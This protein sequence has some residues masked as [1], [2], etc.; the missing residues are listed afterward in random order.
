[1]AAERPARWSLRTECQE[2]S[3]STADNFRYEPFIHSFPII[4]STIYTEL[5]VDLVEMRHSSTSSIMGH[6]NM[7]GMFTPFTDSFVTGGIS[8]VDKVRFFNL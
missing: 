5:T 3:T 2:F 6:L 4:R 1:M 7:G 8:L